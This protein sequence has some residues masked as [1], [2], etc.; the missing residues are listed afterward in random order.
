MRE[1]KKKVVE[2]GTAPPFVRKGKGEGV[3]APRFG[4]AELVN[5]SINPVQSAE[6]SVGLGL[7]L[8]VI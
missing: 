7:E 4:S 6:L 5:Q 8:K 2:E 1:E 3:G